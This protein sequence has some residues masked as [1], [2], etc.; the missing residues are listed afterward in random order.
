MNPNENPDYKRRLH[1]LESQ[2]DKEHPWQS[3][4][5]QPEQPLQRQ[6]NPSQDHKSIVNQVADWFNRLPSAGKVAVV[7]IGLL[8]GFSILRSLLQLVASLFSLAILGVIL[9]LVYK[10]FVAPQSAK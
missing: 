9:Y 6:V 2:L 5:I 1:E 8:V 4:E 10:F 7:S 3:L